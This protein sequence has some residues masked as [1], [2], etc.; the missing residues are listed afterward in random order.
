MRVLSKLLWEG[1]STPIEF[2]SIS[3]TKNEKIQ[4]NSMTVTITKKSEVV[5]YNQIKFSIGD[6][7]T[8]WTKNDYTGTELDTSNSSSDLIFNGVLKEISFKDDTKFQCKL[9]FVDSTYD[10]FNRL[11]GKTYEDTTPN[12]ILNIVQFGAYTGEGTYIIDNLSVDTGFPYTSG[13]QGKRPDGSNFP[14]ITYGNS[15]KPIFEFLNDLSQVEYTNTSS[16]IN[17]NTLVCKRPFKYYVDR[18]NTFHWFYPDDTPSYEMQ[19]GAT[20]AIS[21]D[22]I[23]HR[24]LSDSLKL[25]QL[26]EVNFI[27]FKAG[28][29]MDNVQVLD[30]DL[31][32][33]A[34]SLTTADSFRNWEH[35]A[36]EMKLSDI[37][38]ITFVSS[39][40]YDYPV[41][42][43]VVPKWSSLGTSVSSDNE[44][45]EAFKEEATFRAKAKCKSLF[46]STGTARWS[47]SI[48]LKGEPIEPTELIK[49]NKSEFGFTNLLLRVNSV[50]HDISK[51]SFETTIKV[52]EDEEE[53][54]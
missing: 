49:Y 11:W 26:D 20:S 30:Y 24:I 29:D 5:K 7:F 13:I 22:T 33:T 54:I 3:V 32:P 45:N 10:L 43:P 15:H 16:E 36:R 1:S 6:S 27:I 12:V 53:R 8:L 48:K 46:S 34:K 28:E 41:S 47:G 4:S 31:D 2:D 9:T 40:T 25:S 51:E 17:N 19:Y 35:I 44:Y 42:Y 21:N 39:D 50:T 23:Y 38:N 18:Y 14:I 52:Q 37:G